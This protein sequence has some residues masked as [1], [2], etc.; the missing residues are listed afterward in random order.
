[1]KNMGVELICRFFACSMRLV[2]FRVG[3]LVVDTVGQ[4]QGVDGLAPQPI[5]ESLVFR[6]SGV[7]SDW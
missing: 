4:L 2:D 3:L 7:M 6:F 1:M 5:P